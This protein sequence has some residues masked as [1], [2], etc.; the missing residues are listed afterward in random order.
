MQSERDPKQPEGEEALWADLVARLQAP[1]DSFLQESAGTGQKLTP[2]QAEKETDPGDA[3]SKGPSDYDPLGVWKSQSEPVPAEPSHEQRAAASSKATAA[4]ASN[5][6]PRDYV[7]EEVDEDFVPPTP[8]PFS[9]SE[10]AL[11]AGWAAAVGAPIILLLSAIFWRSIPLVFVIGL[12]VVFL[13]G[14]AYLL[15]RL[16]EHRDHNDG[17]GAVV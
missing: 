2:Q 14:V 15:S 9:T 6:G 3:E 16:P 11:V 13:G 8:Q 12:V 17:D 10:P 4:D 1:D 5:L 7:V